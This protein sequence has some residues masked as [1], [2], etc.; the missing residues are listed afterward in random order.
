M[1]ESITISVIVRFELMISS[2]VGAFYGG[3]DEKAAMETLTYAA[4]RG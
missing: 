2:G 4:D 1:G 3:T